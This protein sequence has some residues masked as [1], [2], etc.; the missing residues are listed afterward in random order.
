MF[1]N[2]AG[3]KSVLSGPEGLFMGLNL[4]KYF[5]VQI[6]LKSFDM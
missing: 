6:L 3:F 5:H 2:H 1:E 4:C